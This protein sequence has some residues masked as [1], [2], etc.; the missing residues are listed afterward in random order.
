[1]EKQTYYKVVALYQK[2]HK[3]GAFTLYACPT[4]ETARYLAEGACEDFDKGEMEIEGAT[5]VQIVVVYKGEVIY[6]PDYSVVLGKLT[7][8]LIKQL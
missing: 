6:S 7:K 5:G 8:S 3:Q 4:E 1:M 2:P